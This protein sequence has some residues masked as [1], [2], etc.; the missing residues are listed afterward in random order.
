MIVDYTIAEFLGFFLIGFP[1][2]IFIPVILIYGFRSIA[3]EFLGEDIERIYHYHYHYRDQRE[4][5][6]K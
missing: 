6:E 5:G 4:K 1:M 2:L 3:E